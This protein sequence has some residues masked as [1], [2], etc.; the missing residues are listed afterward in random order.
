[1]KKIW[2]LIA[3][4]AFTISVGAKPTDKAI[5]NDPAFKLLKKLV[6]GKWVG[7]MGETT[8]E[9]TFK[10]ILDGSGIV[11]H[12]VV[13]KGTSNVLE[14]DSRF[15]WDAATSKV[16]YLDFHGNDTVY[17]G[18]VTADKGELAME[19][20]SIVGG[21]GDYVGFER[22]LSDDVYRSTLKQRKNGQLIDM[23]F[24]L[25]LHRVKN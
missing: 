8:V 2:T 3:L 1:M 11:G 6:G 5:S 12:G 18:H 10:T 9:L 13:G 7:K 15:G 23:H 14:L 22:F 25:E 19:F 16:Y 24:E 20:S 21:P 17:Y 4:A